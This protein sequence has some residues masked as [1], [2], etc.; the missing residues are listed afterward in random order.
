MLSRRR[1]FDNDFLGRN[2]HGAAVSPAS[3]RIA[4]AFMHDQGVANGLPQS[5][6]DFFAVLKQGLDVNGSFII[7]N[8]NQGANDRVAK[9]VSKA[10][11]LCDSATPT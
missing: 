9:V 8:R 10:N 4:H 11:V 2:P 7:H 5:G 6:V 1:L 3:H